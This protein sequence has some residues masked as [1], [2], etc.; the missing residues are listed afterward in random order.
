LRLPCSVT[1]PFRFLRTFF[2][3][4]FNVTLCFTILD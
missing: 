3:Q 2:S 1:G 4:A